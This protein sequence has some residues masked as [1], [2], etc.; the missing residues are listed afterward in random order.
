MGPL[1]V[2]PTLNVQTDGFAE[3]NNGWGGKF[4]EPLRDSR[5][6]FE[7]SNEE[8]LNA[9]LNLGRYG[10]IVGRTSAIFSM[11][12]GGLDAGATN[13]DDL[14][15][16]DYALESG[17]LEWAS[18][19]LFPELGYD[20][21][22]I[23]GG[24]QNFIIAD[25]FLFARGAT[26]GGTRGASWLN[27]RTA[28]KQ[29]GIVSLQ[30]RDVLL[31]GFYLEPNYN[32]ATHTKLGGVNIETPA[33]EYAT[34]GFTYC[35]IFDSDVQTEKGLNVF[36]GRWAATPL[37]AL[38]DFHLVSALAAES[39]GGLVSGATGWYVSPSYEFSQY[40]WEPKLSYRYAS[41]SGGGSNGDRNFDPLFFG[42][43][44]WGTWYQGEILG[45]WVTNNSNLITHQVR[46]EFSPTASTTV[47][48]IFYKFLLY[49]TA[50]NLV[51]KPVMPVTSKN[52][53]DEID[54]TVEYA[55]TPWWVIA[56]TLC[57]SIPDRAATQMTGGTETWMQSMLTTSVTF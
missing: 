2:T 17:Y 51:K 7:Q 15:P 5:L 42:S 38:P 57:A 40:R 1:L 47:N 32:P 16:W 34:I 23:S 37:P 6:F 50:Q 33:G 48:L 36:Y 53:A 8:G 19:P 27:P 29:T 4:N 55:P 22:T 31:Q 44:D 10:I 54:L 56:L 26:N 9:S 49:S 30:L 12:G 13:A 43:I 20:V 11:T 39:N 21:V 35:N 25:G 45:N 46:L 24:P 14:H 52:L 3:A 28:F 18:G 41:F